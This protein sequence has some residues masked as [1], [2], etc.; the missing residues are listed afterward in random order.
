MPK[1][2]IIRNRA[3]RLPLAWVTKCGL[4]DALEPLEAP[5]GYQRRWTSCP[6]DLETVWATCFL[7]KGPSPLPQEPQCASSSLNRGWALA[8]GQQKAEEEEEE[9]EDSLAVWTCFSLEVRAPC[10][11]FS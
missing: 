10:S 1:E 4:V 11:C 7:W 6:F 8:R 2:G 3:L 9:E 5:F